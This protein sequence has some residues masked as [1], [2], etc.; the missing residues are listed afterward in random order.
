ML[1][2]DATPRPKYLWKR[3]EFLISEEGANAALTNTPFNSALKGLAGDL[4]HKRL[5][6]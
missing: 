2:G 3:V 5:A 4:R 1:L 6:E